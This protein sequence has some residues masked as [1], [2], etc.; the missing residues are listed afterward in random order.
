M[1][2]FR[3][4]DGSRILLSLAVSLLLCAI[5]LAQ[6]PELLNMTDDTTNDFT[7]PNS[8]SVVHH[9]QRSVHAVCAAAAELTALLRATHPTP[10][11]TNYGFRAISSDLLILHSVFRT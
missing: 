4:S 3:R 10:L 6:F 8:S 9:P 11:T 2:F 7:I 1:M 5:V